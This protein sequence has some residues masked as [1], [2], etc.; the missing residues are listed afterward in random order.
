VA[1]VGVNN[2][3]TIV[4][5]GVGVSVGVAVKVA[6]AVGV[7]DGVVNK[8]VCVSAALAVSTMNVLIELGSKVGTGATGPSVGTHARMTTAIKKTVTT[9][10]FRRIMSQPHDLCYLTIIATYG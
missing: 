10:S 3:I 7:E 5:I 1:T 2:T 8:A 4:G 9:L 6:V